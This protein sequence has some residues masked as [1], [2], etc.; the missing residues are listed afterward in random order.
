[1]NN[2]S[3]EQY[4]CTTKCSVAQAMAKID[5]NVKGILFVVED[6]NKLIGTVTDGDI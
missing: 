1:M 5:R 3:L 6:E 2:K 4:I